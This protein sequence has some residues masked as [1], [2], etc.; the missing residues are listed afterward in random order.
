MRFAA[1]LLS[2]AL[3]LAAVAQTISNLSIFDP[4]SDYLDPQVLYARPLELSDGTLLATWENYSPEPPM[5]YFPIVKS[6]DGGKSWKQISKVTDQVNG[7]GLRYQ[8][9]L[10]QLPQRFGKY[11]KG[12]ILCSGS[13]IPTDL[14]VTLIEVYASLDKGYTWEFVSHVA[15]G[16]E[17]LPNHGLTPVWEPFLM[18]YKNKLILYYSDQRRNQ[19]NSQVLVH[20][21]TTNLKKWSSVATDVA[22]DDNYFARPGMPTVAKLPNGEYIYAYE[23]GG[24]AS[25]SNYWFPVYYRISKDPLKFTKAEHHRVDVGSTTPTGS[26]YVVWSKHGGKNGTIILSGGGNAEIFTNQKLGHPAYWKKWAVPQPAAYT[27]ALLVFKHDP[28]LLMIMG[29]GQLPP[30]K[31]NEI[32]L[33]VVR[34]SKVMKE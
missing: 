9:F 24:E 6:T 19:T 4:P 17:A 16:G 29:G 20:Q 25:S 14:S 8:P 30:G 13:S 33:S 1:G 34:L 7:W 10:Y 15:R 3:P 22:Y 12:T 18:T 27:R 32:S 5:V 26:P 2:L 21:T 31:T 11:P 23:Y 28:D